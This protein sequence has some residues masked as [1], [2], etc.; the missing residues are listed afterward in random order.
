MMVN[1]QARIAVSLDQTGRL[2][3]LVGQDVFFRPEN[4]SYQRAAFLGERKEVCR[5]F[6]HLYFCI[7]CVYLISVLLCT[8]YS[9]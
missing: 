8:L 6:D 3:T 2:C 5:L 9:C 4:I 1:V 7:R